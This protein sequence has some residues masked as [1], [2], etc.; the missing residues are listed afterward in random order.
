MTVTTAAPSVRPSAWAA[1][2]T[3]SWRIVVGAGSGA[4][5]G[6]LVGGVGGRLAMLLL[7]L[8]SS[9][10][11]IGLESD[12]GFEIGV[13]SLQTFNLLGGMT[14]FGAVVGV[15]YAVVRPA[16]APRLRVPIWTG[17]WTLLGGAA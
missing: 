6:L 7:R 15:L 12:D 4:I 2:R 3:V 9:E 5:A 10:I 17:L 14:A 13:V 16:I 1:A 8:T 11:V